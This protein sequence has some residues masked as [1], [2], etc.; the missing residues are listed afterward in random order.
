MCSDMVLLVG[1]DQSDEEHGDE[2]GGHQQSK[3]QT[4]GIDDIVIFE[5]DG[6]AG[7]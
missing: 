1:T 6:H 4:R 3:P 2:D 5:L 7:Y